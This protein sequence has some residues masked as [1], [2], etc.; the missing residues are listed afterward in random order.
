MKK[1]LVNYTGRTAGGPAYAYEMTKALVENGA[2]V[3][4]VISKSV[5]NLSDWEKLPIRLYKIDT[6]TSKKEFLF[7]TIKFCL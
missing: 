2:H 5:C 4:A 6:Y 1:I 7:N 3:C